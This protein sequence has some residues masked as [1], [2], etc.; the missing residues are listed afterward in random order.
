MKA[1][2][3]VTNIEN[4]KSFNMSQAHIWVSYIVSGLIVWGIFEG[5]CALVNL[6]V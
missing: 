3:K 4:N 2:Y 5:L 6:I 1:K